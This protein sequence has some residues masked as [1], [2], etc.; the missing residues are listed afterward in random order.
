MVTVAE[1]NDNSDRK[2]QSIVSKL[3]VGYEELKLTLREQ[4]YLV[5]VSSPSPSFTPHHHEQQ[6][7]TLTFF[8]RRQI[9]CK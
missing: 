4:C 9:S 6:R 1:H 5:A 3:Y 8:Q 7:E 2:E